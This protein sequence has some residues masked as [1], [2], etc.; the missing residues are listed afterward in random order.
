MSNCY[1]LMRTAIVTGAV[2]TVQAEVGVLR[3]LR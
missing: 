2:S 1:I 3:K